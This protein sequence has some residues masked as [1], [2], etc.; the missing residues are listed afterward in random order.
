[1]GEYV[2]ISKYKTIFA[3]GYIPNWSKVFV[4]KKVKNTVSWTCVIS[5]LNGGKIIET[6]YEKELQKA[7]QEE[8]WIEKELRE[9]EISYMLNRTGMILHLIAG[10][11]KKTFYK[12]GQYFPKPYEPFGGDINVKV[13]LSNYATK[14]DL[15]GATGIDTSNLTLKSNL[16]KLKAEIGRC[17]KN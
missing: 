6:F 12:M 9:K 11:I 17:R 8:F 16:G 7:N 5:D 3:K 4:I 13:D 15:K 1:M 2:R 14:A 10:L